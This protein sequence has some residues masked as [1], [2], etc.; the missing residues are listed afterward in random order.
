[1]ELAQSGYKLTELGILPEDW[2]TETIGN[3][4]SIS[5]GG[6][7][8]QDKEDDG[9]YPFFVRSQ[10]I[11]RIN[12]Y[13]FDGEAILTSG[14]GVGVGKVFHHFIGKFDYHQRVYNIHNY[15]EGV[16][17]RYLFY[18]F[19]THF[20][21]R[22]MSMTAKS[23]VDSVRREMIAGMVIPLPPT[24]EEQKAIATA[25]I[26][27]DELI[28]S[29][30]NLITK[31]KNIKQGA[32][33]QLLTPPDKGGNRL[34]GFDGE[35]EEHSLESILT[36]GSGKD[37][38]HLD[39]GEIPVYGT[40]GIMTF[41]NESIY[42]GESAGIGRKG[43][44][45]K[46]VFLSGKF[47]TVDTL[48]YTYEFRGCLPKFIYYNFLSIPWKEYNEASGVPSLN[49]N[50]IGKI[51]ISIPPTIEEQEAISSI[52]TEMEDE[53]KLLEQKKIKYQQIKQ[54]MMQELLT[55]KTRLV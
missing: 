55:G 41:V 38:K 36:I 9:K 53:I 25:L 1:M 17:G 43:T 8:T 45:D 46:P 40:G 2:T 27:T 13:T 29:L 15:N 52:L 31:K 32:M 10:I 7:D 23:S 3:I 54:G 19:S 44:I 42:E 47:W 39:V 28:T 30:D 6:S 49:K 35:W 16:Y 12:K 4:S 11:E 24:L 48:F 34:S 22:V 33:Q 18:Q 20:Y 37:Y 50:T 21:K 26:E 5:T 51:K 14:D